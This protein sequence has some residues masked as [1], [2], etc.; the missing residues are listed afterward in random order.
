MGQPQLQALLESFGA[1]E[2]DPEAKANV[3]FQPPDDI[4]MAYP[5]IVYNLDF[6]NVQHADNRPYARKKRWIV[7]LIS[8]DPLDPMR[9]KIADLPSCTFERA[10]PAD[11]LNH[12]VFNLFY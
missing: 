9:E 12:Q 4:E 11:G 3:Y 2:E 6:E 7:T 10:F 5:A 8:R 1:T